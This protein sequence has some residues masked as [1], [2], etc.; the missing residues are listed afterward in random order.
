M[1]DAAA[2]PKYKKRVIQESSSDESG[3]EDDVPLTKRPRPELS[4]NGH[5]AA[6]G[7]GSSAPAAPAPI[8]EMKDGTRTSASASTATMS[9]LLFAAAAAAN[10]DSST[11]QDKKISI[12]TT[13][14]SD[15]DDGDDDGDDD[16]EDE[17]EDDAPLAF[18]QKKQP[19]TTTTTTKKIN[20]GYQSDSDSDSDQ[21]ALK[22]QVKKHV[23]KE[24]MVARQVEKLSK[25]V[26]REEADDDD[27][28]EDEKPLATKAKAKAKPATTKKAAAPRASSS[29]AKAS[30]RKN[31]ASDDE[32]KD[33]DEED[34][35]QEPLS[36]KTKKAPAKKATKSVPTSKKATPVQKGSAASKVDKKPKKEESVT[37]AKLALNKGKGKGKG[38]HDDDEDV[39]TENGDGEEGAYKW[40]EDQS[41]DGTTKWKTLEHNGVMFPPEYEPHGVKM[42]YEGKPVDL[43]PEAEEVASFFAAIL[44]TDYVKNPVFVKNFFDSWLGVLKAFPPRDGTK[45]TTFEKCDF[46]P[47]FAHLETE[48][49]KKKEMTATQKK[50]A[51]AIRD[52]TEEPYK[53][54]LLDGRKE[55]VGNFR[56]EPPAL[57][58]GR[59]EHPK[60]GLLKVSNLSRHHSVK[61]RVRPEQITINIGKVAKVPTPPAGHNWKSVVH[62]D[63]VTWLATWKENVNGNV[64]Y[65]FLAAG[66]SLKGQSDLKKFEKARALKDHVARIRRD[67]T[68]D[69]K[70][71]EMVVRQRATAIYLIDRFALRN[72]NEKGEDEADTVGCCSLRFEHVTLTPPT[73]VTFDFLG[74][75]SIRYVNEV[76]VDEQVFKNL[77]I[78]KKEPKTIGDLLFDRLSCLFE[79]AQT[80]TV[81]KYLNSYMDG[82]TAKVFRTYNASYTFQEQ[83]KDTPADGSIADK[84]LAYNRA[85]RLVAVLCNHQRSVSKGHGQMMDRM[86]DKIRALKYQRRKLRCALLNSPEKKKYK[87]YKEDESD[88]ED[89]WIISHEEQLVVLEREKIKKR[90]EK[91]NLKRAEADEKPLPASE[92]KQRLEAAD[93]L[94]KTL[95]AER[96]KGWKET[97]YSD[98]KLI[99]QIEKMDERILVAKTAA[100]D[101]DEGKEVS[102]GTSKINYIDSRITIAWCKK[103]DVPLNKVF[104][105]TLVDKF[106]W[107]LDTPADFVW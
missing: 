23:A 62:D 26:D 79:R 17:D 82:L 86:T 3:D 78:F 57:F 54:C 11:N 90:F 29:K 93:E 39:K 81:N 55:K 30:K 51:K 32:E 28:S 106:T 25:R 70:D 102:L 16:D 52:I 15:D 27:S 42:K 19:T 31:D 43:P 85:N 38:K 7:N 88:I 76:E 53:T 21:A 36:K 37:P 48:K 91:D 74:K 49:A 18:K 20:N 6:I 47:I 94:E 66:S 100:T 40:W 56:I 72:G 65:V 22:T 68:A 5:H 99:A 83:L 64:K 96:K 58:R 10:A 63:T 103:H 24:A 1:T 69:L 60:T 2:A 80:S 75:D 71:K 12:F 44:E 35:D 97:R 8:V 95:K 107:A 41:N 45:I 105:K 61:T 89:D 87:Q 104:S 84:I 98:E 50:E 92:L 46:T 9:D 14:D 67:Y 34:S 4:S 59:G 33:D 77:K 73:K 13:G 101:R